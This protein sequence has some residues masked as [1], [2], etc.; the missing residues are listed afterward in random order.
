MEKSVI[1]NFLDRTYTEAEARAMNPLTLAYIGD[2]VFSDYIRK[3]LVAQGMANVNHLTKASIRYVKADAQARMVH[4]LMDQLTE[5]EQ[6]IVR[7][8]RNTRSTPPKNAD[9]MDYR[10][11]TGLEALVGY[12]EL[13]GNQRRLRE[14]MV[15]GLEYLENALEC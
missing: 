12:L 4:T 14:L 5:G 3:Y 15:T 8:G 6:S 10:Y 13:T 7:R 2:G 1:A 11:A 9:K